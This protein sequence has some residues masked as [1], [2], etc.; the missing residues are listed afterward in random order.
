MLAGGN[1]ALI[2]VTSSKVD[3]VG[4]FHH[5][6]HYPGT[7]TTT[8]LPELMEGLLMGLSRLLGCSR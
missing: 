5:H 8:S 6:H 2:S 7:T 1:V 4:P 3:D